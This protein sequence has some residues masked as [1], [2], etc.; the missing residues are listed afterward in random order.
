MGASLE[1]RHVDVFTDVPFTGNGLIV[2]FGG[3]AGISAEALISVTVE[4]RQFELIL[5]DC[6]PGTGRVTARIF[7]AEEELPFAGHPVIGAAAALHER[8][9]GGEPAR[10][11]TF[12]IAGREIAVRSGRTAGY[13]EAAMNQGR[14][15]LGS[16]LGGRDA[17]GIRGRARAR[18]RRSAPVAHAGRLHRPAVPDRAGV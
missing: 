3:T 4:M 16:P 5:A 13:F 15:T 17:A 1:F 14:P 2:L 10:S 7:T 9:Y 11:W 12:V 18:S 6:Q 8:H